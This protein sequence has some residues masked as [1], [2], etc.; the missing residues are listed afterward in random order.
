MEAQKMLGYVE[1]MN[2]CMDWAMQDG[3]S[4]DAIMIFLSEIGEELV[5]GPIFS[6]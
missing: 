6:S 5:P 2:Q 4:S 3:D 1:L